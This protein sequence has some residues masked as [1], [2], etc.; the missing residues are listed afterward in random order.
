MKI[1]HISTTRIKELKAIVLLRKCST[2]IHQVKVDEHEYSKVIAMYKLKKKI[3]K[4]KYTFIFNH[5][6][7]NNFKALIVQILTNYH[8]ITVN[9]LTINVNKVRYFNSVKNNKA[10]NVNH[11][12]Y[13][14]FLCLVDCENPTI[15][16]YINWLN[17]F[18]KLIFI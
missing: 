14:N 5:N 4:L 3:H 8:F 16:S 6:V 12:C 9:Q 15:C 10:L 11:M 2:T 7:T 13:S 17:G 1:L 18:W